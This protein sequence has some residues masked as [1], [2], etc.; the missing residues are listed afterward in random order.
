MAKPFSTDPSQPVCVLSHSLEIPSCNQQ[1]RH[2]AV[3]VTAVLRAAVNHKPLL[4]LPCS[5]W[6]V[7]HPPKNLCQQ[8]RCW[9]GQGRSGGGGASLWKDWNVL[10]NLPLQY[11]GGCAGRAPG[12]EWGPLQQTSHMESA[13]GCYG[14]WWYCMSAHCQPEGRAAEEERYVRTHILIVYC[15]TFSYAYYLRYYV[16]RWFTIP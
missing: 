12:V 6:R 13:P 5:L 14:P 3:V 2:T 10:Q 8:E 9:Q 7:R 16:H 11:R 1:T 4:L 15:T